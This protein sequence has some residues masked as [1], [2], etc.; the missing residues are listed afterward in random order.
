MKTEYAQNINYPTDTISR[1]FWP[2]SMEKSM[3]FLEIW[4][5]ASENSV[6]SR[7]FTEFSK[8]F[9]QFSRKFIEFSIEISQI[10]KV[11]T[12]LKSKGPQVILT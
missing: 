9:S 6:I 4:L 1:V 7:V 10:S 12:S 8:A 11:R 5:I 2:I 3:N